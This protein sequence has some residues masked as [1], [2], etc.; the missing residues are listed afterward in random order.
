MGE[1]IEVAINMKQHC[2][3]FDVQGGWES[4]CGCCFIFKGKIDR[5]TEITTLNE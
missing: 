1:G 5:L 4:Y 2:Y 3:E